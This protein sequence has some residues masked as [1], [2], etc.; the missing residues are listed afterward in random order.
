MSVCHLRL[1]HEL[2]RSQSACLRIRRKRDRL[3]RGRPRAE[4]E[5]SRPRADSPE[6]IMISCD[7]DDRCKIKARVRGRDHELFEATCRSRGEAGIATIAEKCGGLNRRS[8]W[9][10]DQ[11]GYRGDARARTMCMRSVRTVAFS[12]TCARPPPPPPRTRPHPRPHRS[13]RPRRSHHRCRRSR[14]PRRRLP[15]RPSHPPGRPLP[16]R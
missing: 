15:P 3:D 16:S 10:I 11:L 12:L 2:E 9:N 4:F 13:P 6:L 5:G 1:L 7:H 8:W 14:C